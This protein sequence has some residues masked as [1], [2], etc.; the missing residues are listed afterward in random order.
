METPADIL[1]VA[2]SDDRQA[3]P[4]IYEMLAFARRLKQMTAGTVRVW[5]LGAAPEAAARDV[6]RRSGLD[7]TAFTCADLPGYMGEAYRSVLVPA[8]KAAAPAYLVTAHTSHGAEWAPAA[9][10]CLDA[11]CIGG[12][13]GL[14][15]EDGRIW[16]SKDR[17]GGKVK[18]RFRS[19]TPTTVLTV[20][21]GCF[22]FDGRPIGSGGRVT[23]A[24]TAWQA[25]RSRFIGVV[26]AAAAAANLTEAAI[27]VAAG[28]GIGEE[29]NLQW[30]HRLAERLPKAMV[31][32]TRIVCDRGWLGYDRQVGVTGVTVAPAL[33][34][35][36]GIS[37][38]A[39]HLMGMRG[40]GFVVAVN[41]DPQAPICA[42]A[43]VCI[44]ED[45]KAFIPM[46]LEIYEKQLEKPNGG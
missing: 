39:Q 46:V 6:A 11:G 9:A 21:P 42:E 44:V 45:L 28:N 20:Q 12:V 25:E 13:D 29:E 43:D 19:D 17:F 16:F 34:I 26:P 40:S 15:R 30:I 36:C 41:T 33:Y 2:G 18:G 14:G 10:A 35:A 4:L 1:V 38:A 27:I 3:D 24:T 32:G 5:L 8:L 22:Q 31:A 23:T 7:V 37:G